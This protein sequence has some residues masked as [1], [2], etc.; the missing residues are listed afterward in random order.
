MTA[1]N[2]NLTQ[3]YRVTADHLCG[4]RVELHFKKPFITD[5]RGTAFKKDGKTIIYIDPEL[6][7]DQAL[8][9]FLHECAHIAAPSWQ[10]MGNS[11]TVE[12]SPKKYSD[13]MS[14]KN[15]R[16][17]KAVDLMEY[18]AK[19]ISAAWLKW[20]HKKYDA[21]IGRSRITDFYN[22]GIMPCR[23]I[24]KLLKILLKWKG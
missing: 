1:N 24:E 9:T 12:T 23:S 14:G 18:E 7:G 21:Q 17:K 19:T 13:V 22:Y 4:Q 6:R 10:Y 20:A 16:V 5:A 11:T 15:I 2:D 3:L 8:E